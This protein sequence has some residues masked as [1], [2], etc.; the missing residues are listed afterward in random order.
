MKIGDFQSQVCVCALL[1]T[2]SLCAKSGAEMGTKMKIVVLAGGTSTER[3]VSLMSGRMIYRAVRERHQA[4]MLDVYLGYEGEDYGSVFEKECDWAKDVQAIGTVN[5][6]ISAVKAMRAGDPEVFF[7]PHV[8]DIC[9]Q[10]DL[11]FLAL[12]GENGE[13]GRLQAAFDLFHIRYTGTDYVSSA[14][15]MDKALTKMVF[16]C[17]RIPTPNEVL[18]R[19]GE[20]APEVSFPC[21]V[22][23]AASGSSVGVYLVNNEEEYRA[24]MRDAAGYGG[25]ILIED[26]IKGREFTVCVIEGKA[27]PVVEIAPK[28]GFYDYKNK[29]QAGSTVETCPAQLSPEKT[30]ELQGIAVQAYHAL[31]IKTY[32]RFDFMMDEKERF[33]CLE[34]N[35]LPGMTPTSLIPQEAAA[36]GVDFAGLCE[37][38]IRISMQKYEKPVS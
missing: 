18:V 10:A 7:G 22:K 21:V 25:D 14:L 32:A 6:D 29:Y 11:V 26:F 9:Q 12:H 27:L 38:I 20:P 2:N 5:P 13:N 31:G 23:L 17:H 1:D 28:E 3:D 15:A 16:R 36:V 4:V 24:A 30:Q 8:I 19:E 34:G 37:W 33:Y 35:T